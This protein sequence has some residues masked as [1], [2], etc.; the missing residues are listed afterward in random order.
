M[1]TPTAPFTQFLSKSTSAMHLACSCALQILDKKDV[2]SL[3][4]LLP[5]IAKAFVSWDSISFPDLFLHLLVVGMVMHED[6]LKEGAL[7]VLLRDFWI[8]CC[9][10]SEQVLLHLFRVL[11]FLH[12]KISQSLLR[13]V[14]ETIEP[15]KDVSATVFACLHLTEFIFVPVLT[16]LLSNCPFSFYSLAFSK[17][18]C[19]ILFTQLVS[20]HSDSCHI[21]LC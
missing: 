11:W 5:S 14:L 8:P 10:S 4:L 13:E 7:L 15:G 3:T 9:Q 17:Y 19:F 16:Q 18:I 21:S 2:K 6:V 1:F 12:A 20:F